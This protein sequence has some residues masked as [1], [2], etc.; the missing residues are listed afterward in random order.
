[1]LERR[2]V[3]IQVSTAVASIE[4]GRV[5]LENDTIDAGTIVLTAGSV[6]SAVA[7]AIPLVREQRGRIAVDSTMRSR[8]HPQQAR[9]L[10][11]RSSEIVRAMQT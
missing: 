4:T 7:S 9:Q 11:E 3:D 6:P 1:V 2:G 8:S 5:R 10:V